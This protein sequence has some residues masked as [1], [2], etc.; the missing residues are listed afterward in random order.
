MN[1]HMLCPRCGAINQEGRASC[2]SC[3]LSFKAT[4]RCPNCGGRGIP[5][6]AIFCPMCGK[7]MSED[8]DM[9]E[10]IK[11]QLVKKLDNAIE[12]SKAKPKNSLEDEIAK[13]MKW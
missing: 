3:G 8:S 9:I 11:K 5:T 4:T 12:V 10:S 1:E 2:H 13:L 7:Q 6:Y